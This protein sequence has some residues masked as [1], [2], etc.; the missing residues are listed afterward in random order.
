MSDLDTTTLFGEE[1]DAD[2]VPW[3]QGYG[4]RPQRVERTL[5]GQI[6]LWG[7]RAWPEGY[8][9]PSYGPVPD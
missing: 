3:P 1:S 9:P 7:T 2:L 8:G 4:N 6:T 5:F